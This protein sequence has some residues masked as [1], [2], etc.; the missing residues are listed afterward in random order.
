M[1]VGH[2]FS[3]KTL[4]LV[5]IVLLREVYPQHL[6][7]LEYSKYVFI[8]IPFL[9]RAELIIAPDKGLSSSPEHEVLKVSYCDRS[10]SA[11]CCPTCG[12]NNLL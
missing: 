9:C 12:I 7:S 5:G 3:L 2:L 6:F 11:V 1:V 10:M 8:L 4:L